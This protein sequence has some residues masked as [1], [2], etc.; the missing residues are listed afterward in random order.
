MRPRAEG[1]AGVDDHLGPGPRLVPR[2][3]DA[4]PARLDRPVRVIWGESDGIVTPEYGRAYADAIPGAVLTL[5]PETGHLPQLEAPDR[6]LAA[7]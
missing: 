6:L 4:Q 2:G 3:A 1:L 5:L 7:I